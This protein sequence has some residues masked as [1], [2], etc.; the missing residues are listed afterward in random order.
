MWKM[1]KFKH[2]ESLLFTIG[3][4]SCGIAV[5]LQDVYSLDPINTGVT[6]SVIAMLVFHV[7]KG[8]LVLQNEYI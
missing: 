3:T 2:L 5:Y 6:A 7:L 4:I 8:K 1:I